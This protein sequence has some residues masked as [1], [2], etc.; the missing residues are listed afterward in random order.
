MCNNQLRT[1]KWYL[2]SWLVNLGRVYSDK[3]CG[4]EECVDQ[5]ND[6]IDNAIRP[7]RNDEIDVIYKGKRRKG[8]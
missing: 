3:T 5:Q 8:K 6:D 4:T 2:V 7:N 1:K